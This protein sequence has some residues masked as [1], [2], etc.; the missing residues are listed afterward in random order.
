MDGWC[1]ETNTV[2][3]FHGCYWH[4]HECQTAQGI[5]RNEKNEKSMEQLYAETEK[6]SNYI[7]KCGYSLVEIWECQ[8]KE[9]K[10]QNPKLRQFLR[11]FRRPL[12]YKQ[13]M[14]EAQVLEAVKEGTL[15]GM[16]GV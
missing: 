13:K 11:R 9:M 5:T 15:F 12:D 4:G 3:Q 8:W 7:C 2:Y 14:T 6:N 1:A 10:K 16:V